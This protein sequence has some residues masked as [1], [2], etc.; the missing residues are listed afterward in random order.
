MNIP[1]AINPYTDQF[2]V[3]DDATQKYYLTEQALINEGINIRGRLARNKAITPEFVINGFIKRVTYEV[4]TFIH[5]HNSRTD[6]QDYFIAVCPSLRE[7]IRLAL[8]YQALNMWFN[9]DSLLSTD[10]EIR[11]NYMDLVAVDIL[12][13]KVPELD[14]PITYR[15]EWLYV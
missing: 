8:T 6:L 13:E 4:Y 5:K 2:L 14:N 12:N 7:K 9:G 3:W 10:K 15:G 1:N 11:N